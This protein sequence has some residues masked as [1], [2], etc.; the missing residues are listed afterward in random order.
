MTTDT[1]SLQEFLQTKGQEGILNVEFSIDISLCFLFLQLC[2][3]RRKNEKREGDE[4][5]KG[6]GEDL[7]D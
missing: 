5:R 6:G 7:G 2:G 3:R 1:L 4:R